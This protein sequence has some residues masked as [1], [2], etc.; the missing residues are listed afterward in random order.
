[1]CGNIFGHFLDVI[2]PSIPKL[3]QFFTIIRVAQPF[4]RQ[5]D[6]SG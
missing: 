2:V 5:L 6:A 1:M 3:T 4:E